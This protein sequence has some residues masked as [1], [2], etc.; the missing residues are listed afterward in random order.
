MHLAEKQ[1]YIQT[2]LHFHRQFYIP[3]P[4]RINPKFN[5]MKGKAEKSQYSSFCFVPTIGTVLHLI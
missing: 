1:L 4:F 2:P 5:L 3:F